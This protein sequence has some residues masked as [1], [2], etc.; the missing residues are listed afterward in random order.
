MRKIIHI[1]MDA[2]FASIEQRDN[3][4]LRGKPVAVGG[5]S[6]RGVVAAASYEA[7]KYGV[8]S[9]MPSVTAKRLCPDLIFVNGRFEAYKSVSKQIRTIFLDYTDLVEPLSLDEAYLDVTENHKNLPSATLIA[10]E[11]RQRI[12]QQT[13]LTASAGV[14]YN[15]FLA[16]MASDVNKPNGIKIIKPNEA[17]DFLYQLPIGKFYGIG[18]VTAEKF[19]KMNVHNGFD[20]SQLSKQELVRQFGKSGA[21][22]FDIVRGLDERE[23]NPHRVRK[24]IGSEQTY[25]QDLE[26]I[27]T[28]KNAL[29]PLATDILNYA[30]KNNN[31][32]RTV[33]LKL[34]TPD[35]QQFTRSRTLPKAIQSLDEL[36]TVANELL[37][38]GLE[39]TQGKVRLLG[40]SFSHLGEQDESRATKCGIQLELDF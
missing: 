12:W 16:K 25:S 38:T 10:Q 18:K 30:A 19:K 28:M 23:V 20:L 24:S 7:R 1:D 39:A 31:F 2:F 14:S 33:T 5:S 40:L 13:H 27:A 15:K 3:P 17:I 29:I 22:Y 9:A 26:D 32:G 37:A 34:K 21:W 6:L 35:F 36:I 11:I 4:E 8:R